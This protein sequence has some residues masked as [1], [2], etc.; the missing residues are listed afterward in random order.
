MKAGAVA[1]AFINK[2][3]GSSDPHFLSKPMKKIRW[4]R[5]LGFSGIAVI[6]IYFFTNLGLAWA[7]VSS[8]TNP[9][10]PVT[11]PPFANFPTPTAVELTS[12]DGLSLPARYYPSKNQAAVIALGGIGGAVGAPLPPIEILLSHG[13]GVLQI[14]S[15]ACADPASKV[16]LGYNEAEDA[17][18]GY[19]FL[20][21]LSEVDADRIGAFGFS[22]GG[23]AAIRA[24][25]RH[26]GIAAVI[27]EGGYYNLG[28]DIVE[29]GRQQPFLRRIFLWMVAAVFQIQT[30]INPWE[31]SPIDDLPLISPRPIQLIYGEFEIDE[32]RADQQFAAAREPKGLWIVPE[33]THGSNFSIFPEAYDELVLQ[34]FSTHLLSAAPRP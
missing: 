2:K 17:T 32:S 24:A 6:L 12:F 27:A 9:G 11:P 15:R 28:G 10:C 20:R 3:C 21:T 18:S 14:G 16:T 8:L 29:G 25:A 13:F 33:G 7:Y 5:V 31:S 19:E 30:G 26:R 34:F 23:V 4:R 22:M 1:S